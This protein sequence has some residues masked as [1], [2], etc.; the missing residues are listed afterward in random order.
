MKQSGKMYCIDGAKLLKFKSVL[1]SEAIFSK[2]Y[3]H[4]KQASTHLTVCEIHQTYTH[5]T[6]F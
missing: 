5:F 1:G 4:H 2:V 6:A 3:E